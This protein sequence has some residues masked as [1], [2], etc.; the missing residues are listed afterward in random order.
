MKKT[1]V[2]FC[3][4]VLILTAGI[5]SIAQAPTKLFDVRNGN[6][7]I[8]N[9]VTQ[10]QAWIDWIQLRQLPADGGFDFL[11]LRHKRRGAGQNATAGREIR[12]SN[13]RRLCDGQ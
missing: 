11:L 7:I 10:P 1:F 9:G 8:D 2:A 3:L 12:S 6:G 5:V 4:V 13:R